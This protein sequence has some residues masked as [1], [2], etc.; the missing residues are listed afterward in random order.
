[1]LSN[2]V[3]F[4]AVPY[5]THITSSYCGKVCLSLDKEGRE[6]VFVMY[7]HGSWAFIFVI[8]SELED[9]A[10]YA[11]LLLVLLRAMAFGQGFVAL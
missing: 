4:S 10:C 8:L 3:E 7:K 11:G 5:I 2:T 9:T 6:E 1:M